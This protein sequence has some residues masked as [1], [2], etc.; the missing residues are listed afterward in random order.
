MCTHLVPYRLPGLPRKTVS[1]LPA[2]PTNHFDPVTT[3]VL[4]IPISHYL[5]NCVCDH[6]KIRISD[7]ICECALAFACDDRPVEWVVLCKT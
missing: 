2:K 6:F 3:H 5:V 1:I 4:T 7:M